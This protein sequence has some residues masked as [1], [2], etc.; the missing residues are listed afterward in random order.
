MI[1]IYPS[2]FPNNDE[3]SSGSFLENKRDY[4]FDD[5]F[6]D[7]FN[8]EENLSHLSINYQNNESEDK[9]NNFF[10]QY[11]FLKNEE[12]REQMTLEEIINKSTKTN[13]ET[14]PVSK[15][16]KTKKT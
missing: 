12:E 13:S 9:Y 10:N 7:S 3:M 16:K 1:T 15:L 11:D 5:R 6:F 2:D 4:S 8:H 14:N